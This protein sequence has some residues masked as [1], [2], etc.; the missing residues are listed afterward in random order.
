MTI[1]LSKL[2]RRLKTL[3]EKLGWPT[4]IPVFGFVA[5]AIAHAVVIGL[6]GDLLNTQEKLIWGIVAF[7]ALAVTAFMV[8]LVNN[9]T[10]ILNLVKS[11]NRKFGLKA[12]FIREEGDGLT[13]KRTQE[14]IEKSRIARVSVLVT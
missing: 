14:L 1:R 5:G 3:S 13:Y 4:L 9:Q 8:L 2:S 7:L 12:E 11:L 10:K 6:T